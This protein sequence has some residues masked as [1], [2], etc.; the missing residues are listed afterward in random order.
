MEEKKKVIM[1]SEGRV[2]YDKVV[3]SLK[4]LGSKF[5]S[6]LQ[7][8]KTSTRTKTYETVNTV[9]EDDH[10]AAP[11]EGNVMIETEDGDTEADDMILISEADVSKM[12]T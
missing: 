5:F 6:E 8:A 10:T 4:L 12:A 7:N 1:D 11:H 9:D 2:E 3:S